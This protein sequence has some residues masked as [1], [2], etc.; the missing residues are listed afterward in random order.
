MPARGRE[1]Q[2]VP[3]AFDGE[4]R[5][6]EVPRSR[7]SLCKSGGCDFKLEVFRLTSATLG[8]RLLS[9]GVTGRDQLPDPSGR[10]SEIRLQEVSPPEMRVKTSYPDM[11]EGD[12]VPG[13]P[14]TVLGTNAQRVP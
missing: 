14:G 6:P 3:S 5:H 12:H 13:A 4:A 9:E 1:G 8:H 7:W 11:D 10:V 2:R